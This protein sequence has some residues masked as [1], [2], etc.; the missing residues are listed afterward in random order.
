MEILNC[1]AVK[2][3]LIPLLRF[4]DSLRGL[5]A[6]TVMDRRF[7]RVRP[8]AAASAPLP[9]RGERIPPVREGV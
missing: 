5:P 7:F 6:K 9:R 8:I 1:A 4:N 3:G 2:A